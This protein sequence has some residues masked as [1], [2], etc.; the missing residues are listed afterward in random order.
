MTC[1]PACK[2]IDNYVQLHRK[3]PF[4]CSP[5]HRV[6][7]LFTGPIVKSLTYCG[8]ASPR[9]I[10]NEYA[11]GP[12]ARACVA[13]IGPDRC[14]TFASVHDTPAVTLPSNKTHV[15]TCIVALNNNSMQ[16]I[17]KTS[18]R[19]QQRDGRVVLAF[20]MFR[21]Q[22]TFLALRIAVMSRDV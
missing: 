9:N 18:L 7:C 13:L 5:R 10:R 15:K 19:H 1:P 17:L 2:V 6:R 20:W 16:L 3:R 14:I 8:P 21:G 12:S 4:R 11:R 22:R